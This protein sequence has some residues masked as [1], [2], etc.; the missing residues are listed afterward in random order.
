M[1][2]AEL[3]AAEGLWGAYHLAGIGTECSVRALPQGGWA[4]EGKR[5]R[6]GG[7]SRERHPRLGEQQ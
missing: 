7:S 1:P 5:Q 6:P 3:W 2:D 4:R